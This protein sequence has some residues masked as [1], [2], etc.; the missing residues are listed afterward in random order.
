MTQTS[1]AG[2]KTLPLEYSILDL[3]DENTGIEAQWLRLNPEALAFDILAVTDSADQRAYS[4]IGSWNGR[5]S[6]FFVGSKTPDLYQLD[7]TSGALYRRSESGSIAGGWFNRP[8]FGEE[9]GQR[10][11]QGF[12]SL[13]PNRE[14]ERTLIL[15]PQSETK[16]RS[17]RIN[18]V[19]DHGQ[20]VGRYANRPIHVASPTSP[21]TFLNGPNGRPICGMA[22]GLSEE[23]SMIFGDI[24]EVDSPYTT[25][26]FRWRNDKAQPLEL[27]FGNKSSCRGC[28]PDGKIA[29]GSINDYPAI[30][31]EG[32]PRQIVDES[33]ASFPGEVNWVTG[34]LDLCGGSGYLYV[35]NFGICRCGWI[36]SLNNFKA[37]TLAELAKRR[38]LEI[39]AHLLAGIQARA[40]GERLIIICVCG[41]E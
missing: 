12:F 9:P 2:R 18:A 14:T 19:G 22:N 25:R 35:P 7:Q 26:A 15:G 23:R 16:I 5:P 27:P 36:A 17:S 1:S 8:I 28:T 33:G 37:I 34:G 31:T 39:D 24:W 40:F 13:I 30:W 32:D 21:F 3:G 10:V 38:Q 29:F 20:A 6:V 4:L 41:E 11:P